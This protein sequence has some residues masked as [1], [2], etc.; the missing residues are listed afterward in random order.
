MTVVN[1]TSLCS[2]ILA[3]FLEFIPVVLCLRFI[4]LELEIKTVRSIKG[5]NYPYIVEYSFK[6]FKTR[7]MM[8][9][10]LRKPEKEKW[11][12]LIG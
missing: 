2:T 10:F 4:F 11:A 1:N 3:V 12:V 5:Y 6:S 7:F 9:P 8:K